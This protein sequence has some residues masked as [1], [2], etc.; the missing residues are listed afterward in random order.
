MTR[1]SFKCPWKC[2]LFSSIRFHC[3][4]FNV[5]FFSAS[6]MP[7]G[8]NEEK[9]ETARERER[10][11]HRFSPTEC[12][13]V[14]E[15]NR[16]EPSESIINPNMAE[17]E[18]QVLWNLFHTRCASHREII[19]RQRLRVF[20]FPSH[21]SLVSEPTVNTQEIRMHKYVLEKSCQ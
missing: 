11:V 5:D 1:D 19:F 18:L 14:T 13:K 6:P 9:R 10:L 3:I 12:G 8:E 17:Y 2:C 7:K 20:L 15:R 16:V 21:D 4:R